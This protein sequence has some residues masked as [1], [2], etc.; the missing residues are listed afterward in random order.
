MKAVMLGCVVLG[1]G[2]SGA[3][4]QGWCEPLRYTPPA[5]PPATKYATSVATNGRFWFVGDRAARTVCA[6]TSLGWQGGAVHVYEMVDGALELFQTIV[7]PDVTSGSN[8]GASIDADGDRLIVGAPYFRLSTG[9]GRGAVFVYEFDGARWAEAARVPPPPDI[10]D[11][12][13]GNTVVL[14]G[15][16]MVVWPN[17]S[18]DR[19]YSYRYDDGS[20]SLV[21]SIWPDTPSLNWTYGRRMAMDEQWL[22]VA[23]YKDDTIT[24]SGGSVYV[25]ARQ[26]DGT[27]EFAQKLFVDFLGQFGYD[28]ALSGGTLFVGV[29]GYSP[30]FTG[31]GGVYVYDY[32]GTRW[33]LEQQL[34]HSAAR[35]NRAFGAYLTAAG[36]V[37]LASAALQGTPEGLGATYLCRARL[38]PAVARGDEAGAQ[39][40]EPHVNV[41]IGPRDVRRARPRRIAGRVRRFGAIRR[42]LSLRP[43]LQGL[44]A[45]PRRR[46]PPDRLRLPHVP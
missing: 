45:R 12:Y 26:P 25:Y 9:E 41:R 33:T 13:F 43:V 20:W 3:W 14:H 18:R 38:Q 8:F 28:V 23:A 6:G 42:G 40:R 44:P 29:P 32:D 7:P 10:P 30:Q 34:V 39:P 2:V 27:V 21:E 31:Q 15:N 17:H 35:Q 46:W 4:G 36:E 1:L 16:D 19:V 5:E 22:I 37:L 11:F 24:S